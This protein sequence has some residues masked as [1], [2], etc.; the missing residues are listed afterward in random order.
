MHP[1]RRCARE[2]APPPETPVSRD[3]ASPPIECVHPEADAGQI[4]GSEA[5]LH[6]EL[7]ILRTRP[8]RSFKIIWKQ[9]IFLRIYSKTHIYLRLLDK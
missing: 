7:D 9:L 1:G 2:A 3:V 8:T 5:E 4:Q 6:H